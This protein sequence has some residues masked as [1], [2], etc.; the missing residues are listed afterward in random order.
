[1]S[2][3]RTTQRGGQ[4]LSWYADDERNRYDKYDCFVVLNGIVSVLWRGIRIGE[5]LLGGGKQGKKSEGK[6]ER[7]KGD[8]GDKL[9]INSFHYPVA[10]T[11]YSRFIDLFFF[12]IFL[13]FFLL[14]MS[15]FLSHLSFSHSF[16]FFS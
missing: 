14:F 5:S 15:H 6:R 8:R 4:L 7:K 9:L 13:S 10:A 3:N 2:D 16:F 1:M 11:E 12:I